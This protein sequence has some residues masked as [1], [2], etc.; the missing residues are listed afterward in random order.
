MVSIALL[1][2]K[3][4]FVDRFYAIVLVTAKETVISKY[5]G[6]SYKYK[7]SVVERDEGLRMSVDSRLIGGAPK[8]FMY[9]C[10]GRILLLLDF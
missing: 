3:M 9:V 10:R 5:I 6:S 1:G 2:V 7:L 4:D 8:N